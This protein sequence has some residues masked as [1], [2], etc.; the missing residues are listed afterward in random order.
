MYKQKP[1]NAEIP[2]L[3]K[4][5]LWRRKGLYEPRIAAVHDLCGYGKCSLGVAIPVLSAAGCDVCPVPT[6]LFSAHTLFPNFYMLNTT[7]ML[8]SYLDA[9]IKEQVEIDV[10]YSGFLGAPEQIA[11]LRRLYCV[12]PQALRVLDPVMGDAGK[13]YPTYTQELCNAISSLVEGADVLLPNLTEAAM[14]THTE[15]AGQNLSAQKADALLDTLLEQGA[16]T[17][18]L[19]GIEEERSDGK[20]LL[21]NYV[22]SQ[23]SPREK[24]EVEK[25]PYTLHG[26][27][28]LFASCVL[29]AIMAEKSFLDA[30][31]FATKFVYD[32][33]EI[34][35]KQPDF[36]RRGISF[37]ILLG[38]VTDLVARQK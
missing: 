21:V 6:S 38:Q 28:D 15:Y 17:V 24:I 26:T 10:V 12:Y 14:L 22:Q 25:L 11:S 3:S 2:P 18:V 27:G 37:E 35:T 19:K 33:I 13:R 5:F 4:T 9:W 29:A 16:K 36:E 8:A 7:G 34:T 20:T 30:V 1:K 31:V 23:E 32:A